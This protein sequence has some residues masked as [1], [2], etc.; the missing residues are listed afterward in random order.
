MTTIMICAGVTTS[1]ATPE[2][3]DVEVGPAAVAIPVITQRLMDAVPANP[4]PWQRFLSEKAIYVSETGE[5]AR[6]TALLEE[7]KPFPPGLVGTIEVRSLE[8]EESGDMVLTTFVAHELETVYDQDIQVDYR[9]SHTWR[10]ENGRWR[11][12]LSHTTVVA[13]DP[14]AMP[15]DAGRLDDYVGTYELS[16]KRRYKVERRDNTL[17]AGAE[18]AKPAPLIPVGDNV[19]VDSNSPLGILRIFV[20][21]PDG[22]GKVDRIVQRRK[23]A[24]LEWRRVAPEPAIP[25]K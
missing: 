16:G 1:T 25:E 24:D 21:S 23:F 10:K 22:K 8:L 19:F 3:G 5:V 17:V 2:L 12:V 11:L 6:K 13:K 15:I 14:P 7:F 9:V 20:R 18:G 4:E